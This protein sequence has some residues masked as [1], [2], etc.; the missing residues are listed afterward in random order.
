MNARLVAFALT[1]S[2]L[3]LASPA[4]AQST[5]AN[6][7][8]G[9]AAAMGRPMSPAGSAVLRVPVEFLGGAAGGFVVGGA[10]L[11]ITGLGCG[12]DTLSHTSLTNP[13]TGRLP[14]QMFGPSF[15]TAAIGTAVAATLTGDGLGG[16][17]RWWGASLGTLAGSALALT[18]VSSTDLDWRESSLVYLGST[19]LG[20]ALGYEL[21]SAS[22]PTPTVASRRLMPVAVATPGGAQVGLTG[23]F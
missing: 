12:L 17:G 13:C 16:R 5:V 14:V 7:Q 3:A 11:L 21:S 2:L 1:T 18:I 19:A 15:A 8:A 9:Y 23:T 6:M 10:T 4:S 22:A 20:A